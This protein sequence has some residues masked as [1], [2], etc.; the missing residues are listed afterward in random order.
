MLFYNDQM[1]KR[2]RLKMVTATPETVFV[3]NF[4][5]EGQDGGSFPGSFL[6]TPGLLLSWSNGK[7]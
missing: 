5:L 7:S 2:S 6:Y 3:L 1:K 4:N